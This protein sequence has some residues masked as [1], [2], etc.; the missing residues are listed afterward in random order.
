MFILAQYWYIHDP[1]THTYNRS[2]IAFAF[3]HSHLWFE[4]PPAPS[5]FAFVPLTLEQKPD[6]PMRK[7]CGRRIRQGK[8][9]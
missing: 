6:N 1:T 7:A 5:L 8:D 3:M 9:D 2:N 4:T